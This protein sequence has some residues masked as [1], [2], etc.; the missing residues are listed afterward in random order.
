VREIGRLVQGAFDSATGARDL[1][2]LVEGGQLVHAFGEIANKDNR[3]GLVVRLESSEV[4]RASQTFIAMLKALN[5]N[6]LYPTI[7]AEA[8]R[9]IARD[10]ADVIR[11][12]DD[13][14]SPSQAIAVI[15]RWLERV[16]LRDPML[17]SQLIRRISPREQVVEA[18][19]KT[20]EANDA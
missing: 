5:R 16:A 8:V 18:A 17:F 15:N 19:L 6:H 12:T 1:R 11:D 9:T 10:H 3:L 4:L 20:K 14:L 7:L 13:P 2:R